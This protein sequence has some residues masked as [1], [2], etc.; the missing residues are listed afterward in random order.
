MES[1]E[2]CC[3]RCLALA[4]RGMSEAGDGLSMRDRL[5][6]YKEQK[7]TRAS[8]GRP[9]SRSAASAVSRARIEPPSRSSVARARAPLPRRS[10]PP[11]VV[12]V[13]GACAEV[14]D[15][16]SGDLGERVRLLA[17]QFGSRAALAQL[18][19]LPAAQRD[20][21]QQALWTE[22]GDALLASPQPLEREHATSGTE[23]APGEEQ[24]AEEQ[25]AE[26]QAAEE[27]LAEEQGAGETPPALRSPLAVPVAPSATP[28]SDDECAPP[29]PAPSSS[30]AS[31]GKENVAEAR[32]CVRATA[33]ARTAAA[34]LRRGARRK[35]AIRF[36]EGV[37]ERPANGATVRRRATPAAKSVFGAHKTLADDDDDDVYGPLHG[38]PEAG[39]TP[40][41]VGRCASLLRAA[42]D[43]DE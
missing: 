24:A 25:A 15:P 1:C 42:A 10:E 38:L 30:L 6:I 9:P 13:E 33:V 37:S 4:D 32:S 17:D 39:G 21:C 43:E 3:V 7:K 14:A 35:A 18:E 2:L 34:P 41:V 36:A 23:E 26:E 28:T 5:L 12:G 19:E 27:Q 11:A 8:V 22:L 40:V 16:D 29:L 20:A 31:R